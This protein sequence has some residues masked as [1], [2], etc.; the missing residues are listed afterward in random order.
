[1]KVLPRRSESYFLKRTRVP[2]NF[3]TCSD[4]VPTNYSLVIP[5]YPLD[6]SRHLEP[7]QADTGQEKGYSLDNILTP[8]PA[9]TLYASQ[10]STQDTTVGR[11]TE[12][13][14]AKND[15]LKKYYI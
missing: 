11:L 6:D 3:S 1:M 14:I 10:N 5:A 9:K 8:P 12:I 4:F 7:V 15:N 13:L 2:S